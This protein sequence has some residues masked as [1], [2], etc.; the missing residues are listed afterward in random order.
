MFIIVFTP[1]DDLP[2]QAARALY[3]RGRQLSRNLCPWQVDK[4]APRSGFFIGS[5][6]RSPGTPA[7]GCISLSLLLVRRRKQPCLIVPWSAIRLLRDGHDGIYT[8]LC[9]GRR[10]NPHKYPPLPRQTSGRNAHRDSPLPLYHLKK[11]VSPL[12]GLRP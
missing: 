3:S 6:V 12:K 10:I 5:G 8:H 9:R 4:N 1:P 2:H 11:K 7:P